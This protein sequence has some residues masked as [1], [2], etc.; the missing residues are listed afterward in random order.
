MYIL[1]R[2]KTVKY[3]YMQRCNG[4]HKRSKNLQTP[5]G[6]KQPKMPTTNQCLLKFHYKH[7]LPSKWQS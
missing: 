3:F 1:Q 5:Q 6:N 7:E 4:L 2:N